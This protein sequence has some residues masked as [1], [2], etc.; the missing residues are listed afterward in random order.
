M[1]QTRSLSYAVGGRALVEKASLDV[2]PGSLTVVIGPNGAGKTTL[3]RMLSGELRPTAGRLTLDG[4]PLR[5]FSARELALRRAVVPQ[6]AQL[7]FPFTVEEVVLL[8][9]TV[10][11]LDDPGPARALCRTALER[12]GLLDLAG[13]SY[14]ALSGGERQRV[15]LARAFAQLGDWRRDDGT[16]LLFLDEPTSNLDLAH[17]LSILREVRKDVAEGLAVVAVL[18]DLNLASCFADR[19]ILMSAG[20]I[21]RVGPPPEIFRDEVLSTVFGC[22]VRANVTPAPDVPFVL[23]QACGETGRRGTPT[24]APRRPASSGAT[25]NT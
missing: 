11:G 16:T 22:V 4:R 18:H 24:P 8:G 13:R 21:A 12:V 20:R 25:P 5:A 14:T 10:P 1:L 2:R 19:I 15:H 23:P 7:T 6:A 9:R 17:Q 3:V